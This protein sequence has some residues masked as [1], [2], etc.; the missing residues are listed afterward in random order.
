MGLCKECREV[1]E[2]FLESE[3]RERMVVASWDPIT[4]VDVDVGVAVVEEDDI[5]C[6]IVESVP[7]TSTSS[8]EHDLGGG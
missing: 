6:S 2:F 3:D 4:A 8:Q 7:L 5:D 1:F